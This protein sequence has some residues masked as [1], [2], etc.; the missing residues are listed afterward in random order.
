MVHGDTARTPNEG[1]TAGSLSVENSG[2][3]LRFACAEARAILLDRRRDEARR[4]RSTSSRSPTASSA[5]GGA[6]A[7]LWDLARRARPQ[8]AKRRQASSPKPPSS[9]R[10]SARA[11]RGATSRTSSPA[12]P[13]TCRT[14]AC[15]ACC[16]A[17]SCGRRRYGAQ[18]VSCRRGRASRRCPASSRS[19][20]TAASSR[21]A[22][23]REE[24]AIKARAGAARSARSGR[25]A[26]TLPPAGAAL[27]RP[28]CKQVPA[29]TRGRART[30]AAAAPAADDARSDATRGPSRR[31][32][33]IGAV[34]RGRADGQDGKLTRLDA[35]PGRLPAARRPRERVRH[36]CPQRRRAASTPKARAATA[37]TAPTTSRSTR[38]CSRA[39]PTA[40]RCKLQ[41]MRDD[42]FAWEPYGSAMVMKLARRARRA[43]QH[44]RLAHDLWSHPHSTRPGHV[45]GSQPARRAGTSRS[46]CAPRRRRRRR[47]LRAA[48]TATR[49][50]S[51]TSPSA[52]GR[53]CTSCAEMPLRTSA[54]RTL[55]GYANVF[56]IESFMDELAAAAGADPVEFRL[57]HMKDPRARAVIE[58]AAAKRGLEAGRK[59]R[60]LAGRGIAFANYKN[61]GCYCAVVADV[62]VD[63]A[64]GKVRVPRACRGGRRR[65]DRQSRRRRQPD[66]GRHHPVGELD[67]EGS[68][69]L[70]PHAHH[71]AL[72]GRLSDPDVRRGARRSRS[73][74]LN[75]PERAVRSARAKARRAR[76][77]RR[78]PTRSRTRRASACATCRSRRGA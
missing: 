53:R 49:S 5:A 39:R 63:R 66:R 76:R 55:G 27:Y 17:A 20:A 78:S 14:S 56:A 68:G 73:M 64:T 74:L 65:P 41:W 69:A 62:D 51:T 26:R 11:C 37:T 67:A 21:V 7:H 25:R 52:E 43:G 71:D 75:Q 72:V 24:Q 60:R 6:Q 38:R 2:T 46:R 31:T 13:P 61:L 4:R 15:R 70:R 40:A 45:E 36:R 33:S 22:A 9:T 54:L 18:L 48:P 32:R 42:E 12:A 57:R 30:S 28:S 3:A 1:M 58:A 59:R 29:Q 77:R 34:V 10:W 16:S 47:S 35:Q 19:C 44:R 23:E 8:D 50:R